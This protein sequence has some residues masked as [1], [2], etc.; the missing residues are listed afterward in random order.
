M[1]KVPSARIRGFEMRTFA[2]KRSRRSSQA[3]RALPIVLLLLGSS[4]Y[5]AAAQ[6][7]SQPDLSQQ[8]QQL[9]DAV[10]RTQAQLQES[11]RQLDVMRK[12]L[13]EL[14]RELANATSNQPPAPASES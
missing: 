10:A 7:T 9:T 13:D 11:Q 3:W 1:R 2:H 5:S 12:Q 8:V 14:K 6:A 4:S